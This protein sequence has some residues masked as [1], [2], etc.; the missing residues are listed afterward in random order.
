M[1]TNVNEKPDVIE[2]PDFTVAHYV[3]T[4]HAG[5]PIYYDGVV[6]WVVDKNGMIDYYN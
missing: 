2:T 5:N 1:N 4:D 6:Y 3:Y